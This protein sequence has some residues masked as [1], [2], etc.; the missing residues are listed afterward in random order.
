MACYHFR[1][2]TDKK[3]DGTTTAGAEH[4]EYIDREGKYKDIDEKRLQAYGNDLIAGET[5]LGDFSG[6]QGNMLLYTSPYGDITLTSNGIHT[7]EGASEQT[8]GIAMMLA[9]NIYGGKISV[10]G[11]TNFKAKAIVASADFGLKISFEDTNFQNE[12]ERICEVNNERRN[13]T[14]SATRADISYRPFGKDREIYEQGPSVDSKKILAEENHSLHKLSSSYLDVDGRRTNLLVSGDEAHNLYNQGR[15]ASADLRW[16]IFSNR[17]ARDARI[18]VNEIIVNIKSG[19]QNTAAASHAQYINREAAFKKRGGCIATGHHLPAWAED[20]PKKFFD[21]ADKFERANGTRYKEIEFSLPNELNL[22]QQKEI[23]DRF[24]E[25]HLKDFYYAYAVHD[26]I[27]AMSNGQRHPHVHIMF[28]ERKIDE[29]ERNT[30]RDPEVF[31]GRANKNNPECGGCPKDPKWNGKDRFAYTCFM[32]EDFAKIQNETLEKYGFDVR[33]D[34]RTLKAQREDAL[35]SGN[36]HLVKLLDRLP[37][38]ALSLAD[39]MKENNPKVVQLMEYRKLR[40]ERINKLNQ[41]ELAQQSINDTALLHSEISINEKNTAIEKLPVNVFS[42]TAIKNKKDEITR[43]QKEIDFLKPLVLT[44]PDAIDEARSSF[45]NQKEKEVW[46]QIKENRD[47]IHNL[48]EFKK[49]YKLPKAA[50]AEDKNNYDE[51]KKQI[52]VEIKQLHA[53]I[54]EDSMLLRAKFN[55]LASAEN[56]KKIHTKAIELLNENKSTRDKFIGLSNKLMTSMDELTNN[57]NDIIAKQSDQGKPVEKSATDILTPVE[58]KIAEKIILKQ[59]ENQKDEKYLGVMYTLDDVSKVLRTHLAM[60]QTELRELYKQ[61]KELSNKVLSP[62]RAL[63]IA[64]NV[65]T[66]QGI[67]KLNEN[68]RAYNKRVEAYKTK[69]V[70]NKEEVIAL[71]KLNAE[72][73]AEKDRL[74]KMCSS[75]TAVSSIKEIQAGILRKNEPV[76]KQFNELKS[77]I[78]T[79]KAAVG[80][81]RKRLASIESKPRNQKYG[82]QI[83]T[84]PQKSSGGTATRSSRGYS[85]MAYNHANHIA[86]FVAGS[87]VP[88]ANVVNLNVRDNKFD[89]WEWLDEFEKE[90]LLNSISR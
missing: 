48:N 56:R 39:I 11:S 79:T 10:E 55:E 15:E 25:N 22:E 30:P 9:E 83:K 68:M 38:P 8:V 90:E 32:R 33:V 78:E 17:A 6:I 40:A 16:A 75:P 60:Q 24:L 49:N 62:E 51:A 44:L 71:N 4:A 64:K 12:F 67:K 82:V 23:I 73:M 61:Y 72:L 19:R 69:G 43:L 13:S 20:S 80:D 66:K 21:A 70:Y 59:P 77:K 81:T 14:R 57:A 35:A 50:S 86:D 18:T 54:L 42:F 2:K 5:L 28:S 47:R 89:E 1:I 46:T 41:K 88:G 52:D 7:T 53:K 37:E 63:Y 74:D 58:K 27:G 3:P 31:F 65:Y 29:I 87:S 26:K 76:V 84:R 36:L 85:N 34:H 45:L